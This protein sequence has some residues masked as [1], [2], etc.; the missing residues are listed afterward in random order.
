MAA[1]EILAALTAGFEGDPDR[2][3]AV[4]AE[5]AV[6]ED[7][8]EA[9]E[10][11]GQAAI[12]EYFAAFGG[13]RERCTVGQVV[14]DGDR[15]AFEYSVRFHADAHVYELRGAAFLTT[16]AGMIRRWRSVSVEVGVA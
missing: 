14:R 8:G 13:R 1:D 5:D 15:I 3:A 2:A 9:H 11:T 16:R 4:F 7:R 10:R 6:L 12:L